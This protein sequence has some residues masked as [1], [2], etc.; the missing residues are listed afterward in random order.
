[1]YNERSRASTSDLNR[2]T[3]AAHNSAGK[4]Y[5]HI[6]YFVVLPVAVCAVL[7]SWFASDTFIL[8]PA[9]VVLMAVSLLTVRSDVDAR[10]LQ[11]VEFVTY[12]SVAVIVFA[13]FYEVFY[14]KYER[15]S[16]AEDVL[17]SSAWVLVV[18]IFALFVA[19]T[20]YGNLW[21]AGYYLIF[22]GF[23]LSRI[24]PDAGA[25]LS[26]A[27]YQSLLHHY[28]AMGAL[29]LLFFIFARLKH[30]YMQNSLETEQ[31]RQRANTDYLTGLPNRRKMTNLIEE[32]LERAQRYSQPFSILLFDI[33]HFKDINDSHGH[34]V[35]DDVLRRIAA[36]VAENVRKVDRVSRWG[37][38][39]FLILAPEADLAHATQFARRLKRV[40][41][42]H[43]HN[44]AGSVTASF[45]VASYCTG[46][47]L[48][49]VL[50]R[51]DRA[52]YRAK[53][54]GRNRVIA[55]EVRQAAKGDVPAKL[56]TAFSE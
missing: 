22:I 42:E 13:R 17:A 35:G 20:Q 14:V 1:M 52:L 54:L 49:D 6:A 38:E 5:S 7:L 43:T 21:A 39:E 31:L 56:T 19:R 24:I 16:I 50:K 36:I 51:A 48:H 28:L 46:D 23:G 29:I 44:P 55:T 27:T 18:C 11:L 15:T 40:I 53:E 47:T 25:G 10:V 33:D 12:A 45:G 37:G 9:I 34:D 8:F 32:A 2:A 30:T 4:M 41:A 26:E 3:S